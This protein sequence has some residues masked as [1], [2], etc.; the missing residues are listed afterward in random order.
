[1]VVLEIDTGYSEGSV[2]ILEEE[3]RCEEVGEERSFISRVEG[4]V[5]SF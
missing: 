4:R 1:M 2:L 3:I 5:D